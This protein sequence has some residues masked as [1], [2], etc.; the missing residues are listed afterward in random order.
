MRLQRHQVSNR[1]E[2]EVRGHTGPAAEAVRPEHNTRDHTSAEGRSPGR[3]HWTLAG[4]SGHPR[5][6]RGKPCVTLQPVGPSTEKATNGKRQAR[7]AQ[8]AAR[9]G[10]ATPTCYGC[11]LADAFQRVRIERRAPGR[12]AVLDGL[13]AST[14]DSE[15]R[16][17]DGRVHGIHCD[18]QFARQSGAYPSKSGRLALKR[19]LIRGALPANAHGATV[20]LACLCGCSQR[21][22]E[23]ESS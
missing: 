21:S 4:S 2:P 9:F 14:V 16:P 20:P 22:D 3:R 12:R 15:C 23:N 10:R 19:R 1:S 8:Q 6:N 13:H 18:L 7:Q 5:G 17:E 11:G